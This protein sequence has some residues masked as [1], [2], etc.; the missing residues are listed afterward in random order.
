[1][2]NTHAPLI[3]DDSP[4]LGELVCGHRMS[5]GESM[6]AVSRR[7]AV[8]PADIAQVELGRADLDN[9]ALAAVVHAYAVPRIRFPVHHSQVVVDLVSGGVAVRQRSRSVDESPTEAIL[10]IYLELLY[11][12]RELAAG[13][14]VTITSLDLDLVRLML[15]THQAA[16]AARIDDLVRPI[17]PPLVPMIVIRRPSSTTTLLVGAAAA[18]VAL[19]IAIGLGSPRTSMGR[20]APQSDS[21]PIAVVQGTTVSQSSTVPPDPTTTEAPL[22]AAPIEVKIIDPLIVTRLPDGQMVSSD[23]PIPVPPSKETK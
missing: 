9:D 7:C 18:T 14:E 5:S 3:E 2:S 23:T 11:A 8:A 1:M 6:R 20:G 17:V 12:Y 13:T 19:A 4:T 10:L 16:V 21:D 15:S 22:A